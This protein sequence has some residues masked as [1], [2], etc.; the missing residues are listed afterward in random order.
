M[1]RLLLEKL[2]SPAERGFSFLIGSK[3]LADALKLY[4][5]QPKYQRLVIEFARGE[6]PDDAYSTIPYEKGSNFILH[7]ERTLGGLDVFLPYI[8]DYVKTFQG[9]SISTKQWKD[10]LYAYYAQNPE[11]VKALDSVDWDV[12]APVFGFNFVTLKRMWLFR[13]GSLERERLFL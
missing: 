11:K 10:H 4:E 3:S 8:Y 9:K 13:L 2:H 7:L 1:E 5:D 12:S 6:D